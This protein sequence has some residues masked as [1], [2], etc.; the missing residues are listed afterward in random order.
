MLALFSSTAYCK[1]QITDDRIDLSPHLTNTAIQPDHSED[2]VRLLEELVGCH[3]LSGN[4]RTKFTDADLANL[5]EQMTKILA[6]TFRAALHTVVHFQAIP[7]AFELFGIDF[8]VSHSSQ[9]SF[10][11]KILEINAQPAIE[12]TGPRLEYILQDLFQSIAKVCVE[13]FFVPQSK[14]PWAVGDRRKHFIK[15]LDQDIRGVE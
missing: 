15:C 12:L 3:I 11:V 6:E 8:L 10:Q 9:Q 2:H 1:P 13:P 14:E 7:N 4:L 5:L